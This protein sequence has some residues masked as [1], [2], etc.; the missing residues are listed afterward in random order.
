MLACRGSD[1]VDVHATDP[2][3]LVHV[4]LVHTACPGQP[5]GVA[6]HTVE[7]FGRKPTEVTDAWQCDRRELVKELP[8][9]GH[10][11]A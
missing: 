5:E 7:L 3:N 4:D 9:S 8:L 1:D 6:A 11:A 10:R 2:V